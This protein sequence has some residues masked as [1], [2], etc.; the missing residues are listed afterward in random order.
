MQVYTNTL[1]QAVISCV[2]SGSMV[3]ADG[4][5][6][7][8]AH[9]ALPSDN[10]KS[11]RLVIGLSVRLGEAPVA[12]YNAEAVETNVGWDLAVVRIT[13]TLD[14]RPVDRATLSLPFVQI[15]D[16]DTTRLDQT[17]NVVGFVASEDKAST[18]SQVSRGTISG[19]TAEARIGDRAWIKSNARIP[20]GAAGGGAYHTDGKLIGIPTIGPA[21][22][23]VSA[24]D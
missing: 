20:G 11:N 3:S 16:S 17:I 15:G 22:S 10:C 13:T 8:N 12:T 24:L 1:G 7:T 4:L 14:G 5:I 23:C 2:G 18:V 21:R 9:N 6:L 19:Y